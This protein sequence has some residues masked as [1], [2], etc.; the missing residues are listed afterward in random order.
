MISRVRAGDTVVEG[1]RRL[2]TVH[3]PEQA[4]CRDGVGPRRRAL[5]PAVGHPVHAGTHRSPTRRL[6][7][8]TPQQGLIVNLTPYSWQFEQTLV[9]LL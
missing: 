5:L 1:R 8:T 9:N 4:D 2:C 7:G 6:S 3:G